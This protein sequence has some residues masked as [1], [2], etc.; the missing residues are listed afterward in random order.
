MAALATAG[1][2]FLLRN[3][4]VPTPPMSSEPSVTQTDT[5]T[6]NGVQTATR[7]VLQGSCFESSQAQTLSPDNSYVWVVPCTQPHDAEVFANQTVSAPSYPDEA[8]WTDLATKYCDPAFH[9]YVGSDMSTSSLDV[10]YIHPTSES[11]DAGNNQLVCFTVD[12]SGDRTTSVANS[13]E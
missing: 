1:W 12:P 2:Y 5:S 7:L 9:T 10:Q 13:D 11:W 3:H 8:G 4:P 6:G